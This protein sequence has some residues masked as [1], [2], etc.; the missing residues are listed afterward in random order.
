MFVSLPEKGLLSF[1]H[2]L[3]TVVPEE[4]S[5]CPEER[6]INWAAL[7]NPKK[8]RADQK[9]FSNKGKYKFSKKIKLKKSI[10]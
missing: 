5:L 8:T 10:G 2:F 7:K 1:H 6:E 9:N 4:E 3:L